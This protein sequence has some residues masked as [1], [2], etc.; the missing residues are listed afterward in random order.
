MATAAAYRLLVY[1]DFATV[2]V[3][4]AENRAIHYSRL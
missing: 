4:K 1:Y 3:R 2:S